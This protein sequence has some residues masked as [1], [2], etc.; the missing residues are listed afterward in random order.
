MF[1]RLECQH[2]AV[3]VAW[4]YMVCKFNTHDVMRKNFTDCIT[5]STALTMS[6]FSLLSSLCQSN[7][8]TYSLLTNLINC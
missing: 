2:V 4:A 7:I 3:T 5:I 6:T 1:V 8:W